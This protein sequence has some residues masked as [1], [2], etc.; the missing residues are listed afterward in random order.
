MI[1]GVKSLIIF[2][3]SRDRAEAEHFWPPETT[4]A[5]PRHYLRLLNGYSGRLWHYHSLQIAVDENDLRPE[6]DI[7]NNNIL[8]IINK[9]A[10][11]YI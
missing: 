4:G 7:N 5:N 3:V 11:N 8:N 6:Q 10:N 2:T 9:N 1:D